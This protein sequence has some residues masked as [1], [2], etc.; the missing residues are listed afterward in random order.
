MTRVKICG[1][2]DELAFDTAVD[3]GA[4]WIGFVFF[5]KSPRFITPGR[6]AELSARHDGG[7]LRVALLVEPS[8]EAVTEVVEAVRPDILQLYAPTARVAALRARFAL[9]VW[10][11]IGVSNP[12][13]R[14]DGLEGADAL[15][16]EA[17]AAPGA[18]RPGGN[19]TSFD[20]SMLAD[21]K[22]GFDW[23][24]AGGLTPGNVGDAIR[25]TGALSVDVSSGVESAPGLKDADLIRAFITAA[26]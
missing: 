18:T 19:A 15:L 7:P 11:A 3:A 6:A 22:P 13:D 20:W 8:D 24:L 16:I 14:P 12:D 4:D 5:P 10:R 1:V 17:K 23:M 9:P 26:R 2:K 25:I 21:W